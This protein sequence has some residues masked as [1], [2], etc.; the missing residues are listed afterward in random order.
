MG[1]VWGYQCLGYFRDAADIASS[2]NQS[3]VGKAIP[4]D[5]KYA[6]L[7]GDGIISEK[8]KIPMAHPLVPEVNIAYTLNITYKNFDFSLL[9]QGVTN[10]TYSFSGRGVQ[11]WNGNAQRYGWKN[12]FEINQYAWTPDKQS[13]G[14]DIRFPRLHVDGISGNNEPSTYWLLDYWYV[15]IKNFEMGY[16]LPK[17]MT[18]SIGLEK[19]RIY[20]NASNLA[21]W[22]NMPFKYFDPEA[23]STLSHPIY[24][25]YNLGLNIT[26]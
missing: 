1:T 11:D 26:F 14:G 12:Y 20:F 17:R 23:A 7:N 13:N 22:D 3:G 25:N 15:R 18:K 4:G 2:P 10:M 21:T 16:T 6:D 24:I 8:D 9:V 19:L 5:L